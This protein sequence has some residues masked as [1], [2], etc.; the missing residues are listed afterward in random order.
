M[1]LVGFLNC[2]VVAV[3]VVMHYH[4]HHYY[5]KKLIR[6]N[7]KGKGKGKGS[8]PFCL[9]LSLGCEVVRTTQKG[10]LS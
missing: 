3:V 4:H 8:L 7:T 9:F 1:E 6:T 2:N 10:I 5:Y